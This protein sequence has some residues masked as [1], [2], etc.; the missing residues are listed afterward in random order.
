MPFLSAF[1]LSDASENVQLYH[2]DFSNHSIL[3]AAS[4]VVCCF[5]AYL[6]RSSQNSLVIISHIHI[7]CTFHHSVYQPPVVV[8]FLSQHPSSANPCHWTANHLSFSLPVFCQC[9]K[10]FLF[11][12]SFSE[13]YSSVRCLQLN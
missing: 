10:T 7:H 3:L 5:R 6:A 13:L 8:P 2:S 12:R 11:R 1:C 9:L 4:F